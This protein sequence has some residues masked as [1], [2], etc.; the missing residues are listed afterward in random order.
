MVIFKILRVF[1]SFFRLQGHFCHLLGFRGISIIFRFF[2]YF[3]KFLGFRSILV[4]FRFW[5]ISVIF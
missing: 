4:I 1:Q 2:G 3:G 5:G